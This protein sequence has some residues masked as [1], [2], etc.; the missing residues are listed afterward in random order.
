MCGSMADRESFERIAADDL[1]REW[2]TL[3]RFVAREAARWWGRPSRLDI[4]DVTQETLLVL[5]ERA[6]PVVRA[7]LPVARVYARTVLRHLLGRPPSRLID[8]RSSPYDSV[9]EEV[10]DCGGTDRVEF[11]I[12]LATCLHEWTTRDA[13]IVVEF[14]LRDDD[15]RSIAERVGLSRRRVQMVLHD[16]LPSICRFLRG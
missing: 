7:H 8:V 4:E 10:T 13:Q 1:G 14:L 9:P 2:D 15:T 5:L 12:D 6:P 11:E 3:R 16:R